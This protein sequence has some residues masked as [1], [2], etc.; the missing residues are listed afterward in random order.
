MATLLPDDFREFLKLCNRRRV[1]YL[2]IGGYA[3][4]YHGYDRATADMDVWIEISDDNAARMVKALI[5]FGFGVTGLSAEPFATKG[6]IVRMGVPPLRLEILNDI[7]GVN[8][9]D[10]YKR[11]DL[12][13]IDGIRVP[14]ISRDD[15]IRN[16]IASGRSKD[17][18][19]L[20]HLA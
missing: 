1:K 17:L 11:R 16:K 2:L 10:C 13:Q 19:D 9:E 20:E 8:F 4:G 5:D 7:S 14:V 15:L 3:V 6:Q 18:D 12:V